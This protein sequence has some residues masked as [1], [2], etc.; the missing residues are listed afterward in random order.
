MK[1]RIVIETDIHDDKLVECFEAD[2]FKWR[3]GDIGDAFGVGVFAAEQE[4]ASVT[5]QLIVPAAPTSEA[6]RDAT[7][8]LA[9]RNELALL[10][11]WLRAQTPATDRGLLAIDHVV[12][13]WDANDATEI[14]LE[15]SR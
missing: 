12:A 2:P 1:L 9:T 14:Q 5:V 10:A 11:N 8:S 7:F 15:A 13:R 4:T 3:L 6:Y